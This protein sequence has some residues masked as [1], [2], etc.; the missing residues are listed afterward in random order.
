MMKKDKPGTTTPSTTG[1]SGTSQPSA[2]PQTSPAQP[3]GKDSSAET[4]KK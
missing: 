2:T 3:M 4:P 1:S